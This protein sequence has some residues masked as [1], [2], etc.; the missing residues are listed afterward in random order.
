MNATTLPILDLARYFN[1]A[2]RD[3]F[4]DQ[5]R[6]SARD[7]GFFYLINHGVNDELQRAVQHEARRFFA[8]SDEQKQQVAMIHSPHF[9][10]YNRAASEITRGKPDW[11]EQF[12]IGA[13]RPEL[14]LSDSD[15]R[16]RRLQGPNLWP[17]EQPELKTTL[18]DWQKS[19]TE[20]A[21]VLLRAFAEALRLP[22]NAF[23]ALYGDKPNEHIK[24]I[25]Y[26]GQDNTQSNQGV[27]AHKD[28]GFLSFLLQDEQKGL[29][30]EVSPDH[31][32]DAVPLPGSFV[33]N[34]GELLELATNGYLRATVHRVVSPPAGQDRL[35]IAFFLGA[36]LDAV[37]PVYA[38]PEALAREAQG[39]ESD[40]QNPLLRDVGWNYL[41]GRL[42]SHPDVAERYY[43]DVLRE[44]SEQL[45]V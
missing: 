7:I 30:V 23:D 42:R 26:P 44:R 31:W 2:E 35:S 18:L 27:G 22:A 33:V 10:G 9:R 20:M 11:R 13:E 36:Q 5:L 38:L 8:L 28:S 6:T 37:V 39:P 43:R 25:R 40:P 32:I 41:K 21:I 1:P 14:L 45:I 12:D 16:W 19:M 34:I 17:A 15:P 29:Q 3:A 4:L 24:L